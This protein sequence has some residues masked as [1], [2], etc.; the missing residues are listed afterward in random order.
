LVLSGCASDTIAGLP[1]DE[2]ENR[3]QPNDNGHPVLAFETQ[4]GKMLS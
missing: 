2:N 4:K 3:D 1:D